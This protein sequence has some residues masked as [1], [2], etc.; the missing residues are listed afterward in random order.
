MELQKLFDTVQLLSN[1]MDNNYQTSP[2]SISSSH[3]NF[4]ARTFCEHLDFIVE[5]FP[6]HALRHTRC[7]KTKQELEIDGTMWGLVG[8][9]EAGAI[10]QYN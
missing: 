9:Y 10:L 5:L 6:P 4:P 8:R 7:K 1:A 3:G 2:F